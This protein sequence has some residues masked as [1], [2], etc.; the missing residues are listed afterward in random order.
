MWFILPFLEFHLL[1]L[2]IYKR[3]KRTT[4]EMILLNRLTMLLKLCKSR[5]E[6]I[7]QHNLNPIQLFYAVFFIFLK[8]HISRPLNYL[9]TFFSKPLQFV[10]KAFVAVKF[11]H[12]PFGTGNASIHFIYIIKRQQQ[13][14]QHY[15][16]F[17]YMN[18]STTA[19]IWKHIFAYH[20]HTHTQYTKHRKCYIIFYI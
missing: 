8:T 6:I 3:K 11:K 9:C 2:T 1:E 13:Q 5:W 16:T 12:R 10:F 17:K 18:F 20:T 7:L 15:I 4:S 14:H 19:V